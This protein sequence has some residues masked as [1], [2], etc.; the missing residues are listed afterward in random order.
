MTKHK[1]ESAQ[2][3][4]TLWYVV[5]EV[6]W[7]FVFYSNSQKLS[8]FSSFRC[9]TCMRFLNRLLE[10]VLAIQHVQNRRI[11]STVLLVSVCYETN[12]DQSNLVAFLQHSEIERK[13]FRMI[14]L[15]VE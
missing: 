6:V 1:V 8:Q 2:R 9:T 11:P 14:G 5:L 4:F 7:H 13:A 10:Y 12:A 3:S 15:R